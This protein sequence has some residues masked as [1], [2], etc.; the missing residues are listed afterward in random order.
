MARTIPTLPKAGLV[1]ACDNPELFGVEL[2]PRQR[3]LLA[4]VEAGHLLHI[5]AL[6]RRSGKTLLGAII[7]LWYCLFRDDLAAHVRRRERRY[8]VAV[9]T[10]L[11]QAGLFVQAARSLVEAS[12]LL[13]TLV[14][15]TSDDE[16][17]FRN[18][19]TLTRSRA[20]LAAV[21]AGR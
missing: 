20:P 9:A 19:T 12:P 16:I 2:T 14:E 3:E 4:E 18:R 6:G 21:A 8:S 11:R 13:A 10:N 15:S 7:G 17:I 1:A 5:W